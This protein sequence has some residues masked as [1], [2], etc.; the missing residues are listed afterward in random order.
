M[1][2]F[3]KPM[4][5]LAVLAVAA[6]IIG[7][8]VSPA[9]SVIIPP[10]GDHPIG[11]GCYCHND[12]VGIWVN[13]TDWYHVDTYEVTVDPGKS[14]VLPIVTR[15]VATSG[16]LPG[17]IAWLPNMT[18]NSR[19]KFDPQEVRAKPGIAGIDASFTIT[20]PDKPGVYTI[21]GVAEGNIISIFVT[22]KNFSGASLSGS[23]KIL[24]VESASVAEA[25]ASV[26]MK[27]T[28]QNEGTVPRKLYMYVTD[29]TTGSDVV[30]KV[31]S[32]GQ[33][34][35]NGT[36]TLSGAFMM[37]NSTLT[38]TVHG[39]YVQD[40]EDSDDALFS[41]SVLA[42]LASP[43]IR[44]VPLDVLAKQWVPWVALIAVSLGSVPL[45]GS[46]AVKRKNSYP[47]PERLKMAVVECGGFCGV[48]RTTMADLGR[49]ALSLL[50]RDVVLAPIITGAIVDDPVDVAFVVGSVRSEEDINTVKKAREKARLL[51]AYGACS[52]F[53]LLPAGEAVTS[54]FTNP[55]PTTNA[56]ELANEVKPLSDYV[57]VDLTIPGCP[58][59]LPTI[60]SALETILNKFDS[61]RSEK[62]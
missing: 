32:E 57:K 11:P 1:T 21:S 58:P 31:Y 46:Y 36:V 15:D 37:P 5:G 25:G 6:I 34:P 45:V 24:S 56:S 54:R 2:H 38:L 27:V 52:A 16:I 10:G 50:S 7:N 30:S 61:K 55:T 44:T 47:R 3:S 23:A 40:G 28:L 35:G 22:V 43:P 17:V 26:G 48:C 33:V 18:D 41:V 4:I 60:N 42:A 8:F 39:G 29:R 14:F 49:H 59:P 9:S 12:G 20:P 19:F 62:K 53:G 51:I 13:A